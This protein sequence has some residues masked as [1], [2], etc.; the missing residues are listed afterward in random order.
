MFPEGASVDAV[1]ALIRKLQRAAAIGQLPPL[2]VAIDQEGGSIKRLPGPPLSSPLQLGA[3][4][5][6][7]SRAAG[8]DTGRYLRAL[9]IN[10]DFA[11][12]LDVPRSTSNFIYSRSFGTSRRRVAQV[13]TAFADGLRLANVAATAKHFP[14]LGL[15][16]SNT[17][18]APVAI[19]DPLSQIRADFGPFVSAVRD[20]IPLV[21]TATARYSALDTRNVAALSKRIIQGELRSRLGFKRVVVTDDLASGA[22]RSI[23]SPA[24][25]AVSAARAGNDILLYARPG[26]DRSGEVAFRR[27]LEAT[28]RGSLSLSS[29]RSSYRRIQKLKRELR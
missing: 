22:I 10:V 7:S 25:A 6:T 12:V 19:R 18:D 2:L 17:D 15:A 3:R 8:R 5:A 26:S 4:G 13:G 9:G 24:D 27:L 20:D 21:M 16:T 23:M 29:L 11:P 1:A 14:G 28:R